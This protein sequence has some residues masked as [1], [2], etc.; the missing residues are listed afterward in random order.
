MANEDTWE[1]W[2]KYVLSELVR[3]NIEIVKLQVKSE[4]NKSDILNEIAKLRAD[5]T[6]RTGL[7]SVE[8]GQLNV[9]AAVW[10]GLGGAIPASI[11]LL[12][13]IIYHRRNG[14]VINNGK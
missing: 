3:L 7:H 11:M 14:K 4:N 8:I 13:G 10:G 5:M 9:K 6:A 2:S 1:E 12:A